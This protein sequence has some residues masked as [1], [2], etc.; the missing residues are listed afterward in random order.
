MDPGESSTTRQ[1]QSRLQL[2]FSAIM[3]ERPSY[4]Q[5]RFIGIADGGR[6]LVRV[7]RVDKDF[8]RVAD[9]DL[10]QKAGESYFQRALTLGPNEA[11]FSEV[12]YNREF[13]DVEEELVPTIRSVVPIFDDSGTLFGMVVINADYRSIMEHF[14]PQVSLQRQ[15]VISNEAGDY[16]THYTDGTVSDFHFHNDEGYLL[17]T[18]LSQLRDID[19]REWVS[20]NRELLSYSVRLPVDRDLDGSH[21]VIT[22]SVP[23]DDVYAPARKSLLEGLALTAMIL[24]ITLLMTY[25]LAVRMTNPLSKMTRTIEQALDGDD[26]L[27]LP[28][29]RKDEVGKLAKAFFK[30]TESRK[31]YSARASAVIDNVVDGIISIDNKGIVLSYN[32]ASQL[33]FGYA[34]DE[35]MGRNIKMLMPP[36]VAHGHD[37]YLAAFHQTGEKHS[38]GLTRELEALRKDGSLFPM[39][40]SVSKVDLGSGPINGAERGWFNW[41]LDEEGKCGKCIVFSSFSDAVQRPIEPIRRTPK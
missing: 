4:T 10:Q 8:A 21:I 31:E 15:I 23:Y 5:I 16:I 2:I 41:L 27:I 19:Q 32:P 37:G 26:S 18:F 6:E 17:P 29:G 13:G 36:A 34:P 38:V 22:I 35:V 33:L 39:E 7:N 11:Y 1:W 25:I 24:T 28:V 30:L 14:F 20:V 3:A 40:L 9:E 12:T